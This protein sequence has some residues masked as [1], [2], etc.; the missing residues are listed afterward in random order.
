MNDESKTD[1]WIKVKSKSHCDWWSVSQ[2]SLGIEPHLGPMTRYLFLSDSYVLVSVGRPLWREG[3]SV[4]CMCHWSLPAQ[5]FS[6]PNPL[7]LVTVI[8]LSQIWDFP[9]RRLLRLAGSRWRYSTPPPHGWLWW[10]GRT[11]WRTKY[12]SPHPTVLLLFCVYP[13]LQ[14]YHEFTTPSFC[15]HEERVL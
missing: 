13:L 9:F 7:G 15:I 6:S 5:P 8:L 1:C 12:K 2:L 4:F 11:L 14:K 3:G 10:R